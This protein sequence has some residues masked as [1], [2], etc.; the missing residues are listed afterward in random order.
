M[1]GFIEEFQEHSYPGSLAHACSL[2]PGLHFE[3]WLLTTSGAC[4][5]ACPPHTGRWVMGNN[6]M[7]IKACNTEIISKPGNRAHIIPI[8]VDEAGARRYDVI[9]PRLYQ[10]LMELGFASLSGSNCV[11]SPS[12]LIGSLQDHW[13]QA[14]SFARGFSIAYLILRTA[15]QGRFCSDC[16]F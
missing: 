13:P 9:F 8:L 7:I 6:R 14:R 10:F 16:L 11:L 15:L 4:V 5:L 3:S 2:R 1:E 12:C